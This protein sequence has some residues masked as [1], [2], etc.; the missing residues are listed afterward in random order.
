MKRKYKV[1]KVTELY[2]TQIRGY[3][4]GYGGF[5]T[6]LYEQQEYVYYKVGNKTFKTKYAAYKYKK[7]LEK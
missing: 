3:E 6:G 4:P 1:K 5:N 7:Q 2:H